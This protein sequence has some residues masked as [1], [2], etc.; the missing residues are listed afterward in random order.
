MTPK[1]DSNG[2]N[3]LIIILMSVMMTV[4]GGA[5]AWIRS[6]ISELDRRNL[7]AHEK[8]NI[9]IDNL[10][11]LINGNN[12]TE[13]GLVKDVDMNGKLIAKNTNDIEELQR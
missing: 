11:D 9:K 4:G 5:L 1:T 6:D 12:I 10:K 13:A 7:E 8:M 2:T 3:K